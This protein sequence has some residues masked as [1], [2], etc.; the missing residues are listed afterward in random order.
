[1]ASTFVYAIYNP[2]K[3]EVKIGY[4]SDPLKRLSQLQTGT[5][6]RL[7]L[8]FTF[9][10]S[11]KE[12]LQLHQELAAYRIRGEW[13]PY[14]DHVLKTLL[15]FVG[16]SYPEPVDFIEDDTNEKIIEK[17]YELKQSRANRKNITIPELKKV[18]KSTD[19]STQ[20][21]EAILLVAGWEI[22]KSGSCATKFFRPTY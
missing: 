20:E 8:L 15:K 22:V 6:D 11:N 14:T 2:N 10:G 13:F 1:M 9:V 5:T 19:L 4:S 3:A 21:I 16:R 12:E 18:I 7:D 17:A